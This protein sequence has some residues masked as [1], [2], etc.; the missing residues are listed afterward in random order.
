MKTH[1]RR[2]FS[3]LTLGASVSLALNSLASAAD[4][5][6]ETGDKKDGLTWYKVEDW[7][8]EGRGWQSDEMERFYARLPLK[9]KEVVRKPVWSLSQHSSGML[10]RFSSNATKIQ[11]RYTLTGGLAMPH[12]PA[13]GVSGIDLYAENSKGQLRWVSVVKPTKKEVNATIAQGF[14]PGTRQYTAY[15]PLYNGIHSL[16]FG[17]P[18]GSTF[19]PIAP[20]KNRP[21]LFYGTSI[22]HGACASRPGMALPAIL[23]RQLGLPTINLGFSG[24]GKMD[25]ELAA[26]IGEIDASVYVLD[27]LP[28]MTPDLVTERAEPFVHQ[29]RKIRPDTPILLVEDRTYGYAWIKESARQRHRGSRAALVLAYDKL[30]SSGI[31][32]LHYMEGANLLGDDN[33]GTTD[34]SHPNDLGFMRQAKLTEPILR[35]ILKKG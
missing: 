12:M 3:K 35:K 9:A 10:T 2:Q 6:K 17:V 22:M 21:I 4:P 11:V 23:G 15:L 26:L 33:E 18:E 25:L 8:I 16:E 24:N 20:R 28:N 19:T 27:C 13:T 7:G 31:K 32:N 5:K 29:L 1:S 30:V 14:D 34:G